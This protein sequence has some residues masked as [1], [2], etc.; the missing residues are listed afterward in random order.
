[1]IGASTRVSSDTHRGGH[2]R[3]QT[4]GRSSGA[5]A[6]RLDL[7]R[8]TTL[9]LQ[10]SRWRSLCPATSRARK[11]TNTRRK[12]HAAARLRSRARALAP[13]PS[14]RVRATQELAK[15]HRPVSSDEQL[16]NSSRARPAS[17]R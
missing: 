15:Q 9:R 8:S 10:L 14:S 13:V 1:M 4:R 6:S 5:P 11:E 17:I 16:R 7:L 3:V 2:R 12:T